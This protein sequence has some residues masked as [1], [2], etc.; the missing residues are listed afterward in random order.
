MLDAAASPRLTA[1]LFRRVGD[2]LLATPALRALKRRFP[3]SRLFVMS[4]PPCARVFHLNPWIDETIVVPKG[5]SAFTL[6]K[7]LRG[8]GQP[9][10]VADFL[11][12][13]RSALGCW[14]SGARCRAGIA[15]GFRRHLYT[16]CAAPQDTSQPIY[17]GQHKLL[18]A[19]ALDAKSDGLRTEFFLTDD[20]FAFAMREWQIRNWSEQSSVIA[21]FVHSR[22]DYKRWPLERFAQVIRA[23]S[24]N[25]TEVVVLLTPG[26]E[27]AVGVLQQANIL[28]ATNFLTISDLGH[29]GAV[30][31]KCRLLIGNDGG[32][33]HLAV[34]LDTPTL[35]IFGREPA[36]YWTPP[37]APQHVALAAKL[38]NGILE[39]PAADQVLETAYGMLSPLSP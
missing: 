16:I 22:R 1:L 27:T 10:M 38:Q 29:L 7:V 17:S 4:E 5:P 6:A 34:A 35:T 31:K 9:D 21:F 26:D 37:D 20:D 18:L 25:G 32:P 19:Q 13:P 23:L 36:V 8:Q 2:S 28:P 12:D 15:S 30:L 33:K 3:D 14:L 39:W 11:S 24:G